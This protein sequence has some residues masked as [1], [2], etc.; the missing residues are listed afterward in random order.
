VL[1]PLVLYRQHGVQASGGMSAPKSTTYA[2]RVA[3]H[4]ALKTHLIERSAALGRALKPG[5]LD[6]IDEKLRYLRAMRDM[7]TMPLHLR[8][9]AAAGEVV[10]GRWWR[11]TP[12]TI[13][14]DKRFDLGRL[15]GFRS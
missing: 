1:E 11:Y 13:L 6:R 9:A 2:E 4:E 12:R 5:V 15:A 3:A 8:M 14:V 7:Q 10:S